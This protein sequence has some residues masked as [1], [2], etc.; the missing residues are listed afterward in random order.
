MP[1]FDAYIFIDWSSA[2]GVGSAKP[3][4]DA[5]WLGELVPCTG[6]QAETYYRTRV[7]CIQRL[8]ESLI[9]HG[10]KNRRVLVG[11]DFPYGYP[12]G[13]ALA[14]GLPAGLQPWIALWKE[15]TKRVEDND[16]NENNRFKVANDLNGIVG[17]GNP[18]PF[19][20]CPKTKT[21][22]ILSTHSPGFPFQAA[23]GV[24][25]ERLRFVE[26]QLRG[27]QE[28]WKLFLQW[29]R[30]QSGPGWNSIRV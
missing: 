12:S 20:G 13:F 11:F 7:S 19:W 15:L 10:D 25:L 26:A 24:R 16:D 5:V 17:L 21:T 22:S 8:I 2:C 30:W 23:G 1:L 4:K 3:R 28:V 29:K 14:L 27:T 18:G 6:K 9:E